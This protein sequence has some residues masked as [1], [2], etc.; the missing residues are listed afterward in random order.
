MPP[1]IHKAHTFRSGHYKGEAV[2]FLWSHQYIFHNYLGCFQFLIRS[3]AYFCILFSRQNIQM[4]G[5]NGISCISNEEETF[6]ECFSFETWINIVLRFL[7]KK[8]TGKNHH[9]LL[10]V[11]PFILLFCSYEIFS[12]AELVFM[13]T[14]PLKRRWVWQITCLLIF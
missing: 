12:Y 8:V 13:T 14:K 9:C 4:K 3:G 7:K 1:R 6:Y 5:K 10:L 2:V 11:N